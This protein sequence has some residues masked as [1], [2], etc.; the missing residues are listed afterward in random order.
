[1]ID[2]GHFCLIP[3]IVRRTVKYLATNTNPHG[4]TELEELLF[5]YS[6]IQHV[7]WEFGHVGW[8]CPL[9]STSEEC[10]RCWS[11]WVKKP[12]A[13]ILLHSLRKRTRGQAFRNRTAG[14]TGGKPQRSLL[15]CRHVYVGNTFSY[16]VSQGSDWSGCI[17]QLQMK[18]LLFFF[19][20]FTSFF[21]WIWK[22]QVRE[23]IFE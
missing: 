1:M 16:P 11:Q 3:G 20:F 18:T 6:A 5:V 14:L 10:H 17:L 2:N 15:L 22:G 4:I 19:F 23:S 8:A 13:S 7:D 9:D 21:N 12:R